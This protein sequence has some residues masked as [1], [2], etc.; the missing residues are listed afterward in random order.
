MEEDGSPSDR[1]G[2]HRTATGM[3]AGQPWDVADR[4]AA[5]KEGDHRRGP[6]RALCEEG[7]TWQ[8]WSGGAL[9]TWISSA[10]VSCDAD[11]GRRRPS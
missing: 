3:E 9:V 10:V 1:G 8:A 11:Q 2:D 5:G 4:T 6:C 7:V